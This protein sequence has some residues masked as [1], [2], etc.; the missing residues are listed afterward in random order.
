MSVLPRNNP[1]KGRRDISLHFLFHAP[2][3]SPLGILITAAA[4]AADD[5]DENVRAPRGRRGGNLGGFCVGRPEMK[6]AAL[7]DS[8]ASAQSGINNPIMSP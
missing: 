5:D 3:T 7:S 4:A 6:T 1:G 2:N 8:F